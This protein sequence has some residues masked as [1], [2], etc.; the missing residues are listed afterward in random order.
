MSTIGLKRFI[1]RVWVLLICQ[2]N[3][4]A[5]L[6]YFLTCH[7]LALLAMN[8]FMRS[9]Q[10]LTERP[11]VPLLGACAAPLHSCLALAQGPG[12]TPYRIPPASLPH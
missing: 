11:P 1:A 9:Y 2:C 10:L 4:K 6:A 3:M 12:P 8:F 7:L 5:A